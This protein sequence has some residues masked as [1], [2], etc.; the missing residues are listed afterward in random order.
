MLEDVKNS[1]RFVWYSLLAAVIFAAIFI[2][3]LFLYWDLL[4]YSTNKEREV[5][6]ASHQYVESKK[7]ELLLLAGEYQKTS[8]D[9]ARYKAADPVKYKDVISGLE[10]QKEVIFAKLSQEANMIPMKVPS[11]VVEIIRGRGR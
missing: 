1:A 2:A 8:T 10:N 9:I 4:P 3:G 6:T 5:Y 7:Q 11:V